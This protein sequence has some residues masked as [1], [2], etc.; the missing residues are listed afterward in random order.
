MDKP[1]YT[2][3]V[4]TEALS[5]AQDFSGK[6]GRLGIGLKM[7][8][9]VLA[10]YSTSSHVVGEKIAKGIHHDWY[11][12]HKRQLYSK[13]LIESHVRHFTDKW[14]SD[15]FGIAVGIRER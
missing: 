6:V 10:C 1:L 9:E 3:S 14:V 4:D 11:E 15:H 2:G 8:D 12:E 5:E 7:K 13:P